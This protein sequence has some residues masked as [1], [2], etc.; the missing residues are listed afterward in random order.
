M[1][2]AEMIKHGRRQLEHPPKRRAY[3]RPVTAYVH[4]ESMGGERVA[5]AVETS[6]RTLWKLEENAN[7]KFNIVAHTVSSQLEPNTRLVTLPSE[8]SQ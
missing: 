6:S 5:F 3:K 1:S 2:L 8:G 4:Y 7:R